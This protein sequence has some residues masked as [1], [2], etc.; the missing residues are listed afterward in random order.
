MLSTVTG[1]HLSVYLG[2]L[3]KTRSSGAAPESLR[4]CGIS[5]EGLGR[6][7]AAHVSLCMLVLCCHP[8]TLPSANQG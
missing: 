5:H 6:L 1:L 8:P 7:L 4:P 2:G 3:A